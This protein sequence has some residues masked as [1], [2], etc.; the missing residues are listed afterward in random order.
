MFI[1]KVLMAILLIGFSNSAMAE[2]HGAPAEEHGEKPAEGSGGEQGA[3]AAPVKNLTPWVEVEA[4]IQELAAKVKTKQTNLSLLFEEKNKL[5]NNSPE[6]KAKVQ[7]IVKEHAEMRKLAEEHQ[8]QVSLLKYR[9]PE[10]NAKAGRKYDRFEIKS[11][12][13]MEQ[14]MGVDGKLSRNIRKVRSQYQTQKSKAE[15]GHAEV[16]P[17][18]LKKLEGSIEDSGSIILQK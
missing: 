14:A 11:V 9:F 16:T 10:R 15:G 2:E 6:L 12:D 18:T 7:E 13:D 5:V 8:K 3:A 17:T 1:V 4:K